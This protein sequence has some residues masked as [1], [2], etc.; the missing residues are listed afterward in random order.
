MLL[1]RRID[2]LEAQ[3]PVAP[4]RLLTQLERQA[5][6]RDIEVKRMRRGVSSC[7]IRA[8]LAQAAHQA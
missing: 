7:E 3:L 6:V 4:D 8:Q 2:K 5:G 1:S